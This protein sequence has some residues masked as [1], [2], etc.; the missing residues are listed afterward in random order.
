MELVKEWSSDNLTDMGV[1]LG[2]SLG[3][4]VGWMVNRFGEIKLHRYLSPYSGTKS[5]YLLIVFVTI[6]FCNGYYLC[7]AND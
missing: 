3:V 5:V 4:M 2:I 7:L 1:F 6:L